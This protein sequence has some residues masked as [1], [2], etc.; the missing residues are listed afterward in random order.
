MITI[1]TVHSDED[2]NNQYLESDGLH[3]RKSVWM[4]GKSNRRILISLARNRRGTHVKELA[5]ARL[6]Q[7][8][9]VGTKYK[10]VGTMNP[11]KPGKSNRRII[12]QFA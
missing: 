11:S 7:I 2:R 1:Y 9:K 3:T 10:V 5:C 8:G 4:A 6:E 12:I